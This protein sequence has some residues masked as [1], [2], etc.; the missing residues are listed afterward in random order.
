MDARTRA[1]SLVNHAHLLRADAG[2]T[3]QPPVDPALMAYAALVAPESGQLDVARHLLAGF[4]AA[5]EDVA[6]R[7][8]KA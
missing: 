8:S 6:A 2:E 4:V 1:R 7:A 3:D 5:C